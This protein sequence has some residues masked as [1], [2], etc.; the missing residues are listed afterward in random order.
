MTR[1]SVAVRPPEGVVSLIRALPRPPL[2]GVHWSTPERW[3][4]KVRPLGH[5]APALVDPLVEALRDELDGAPAVTCRLGPATVRPGGQWLGVPVG[6]LEEI[7]A[8]VFAATSPVVPV[9]HPQPFHAEL[10]L[11]SGRVPRELAG[12]PVEARWQADRLV[13]VADRSAPSRPKLVDVADIPLT[14]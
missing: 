12:T 10:V 9:T 3:I 6:G 13:L 5:V 2:P 14:G 8:A 11:A 7:G 1:L 4:I